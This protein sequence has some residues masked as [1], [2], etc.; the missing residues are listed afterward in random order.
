MKTRLLFLCLLCCSWFAHAQTIM[1][2]GGAIPDN[3]VL[4]SFPVAVRG[5]TPATING[6]FGLQSVCVTITHPWVGDLLL[7]LQAPDGT[8]LDLS[9]NNGGS[10]DNYTGT[11]FNST[12]TNI[13]SAGA[14]PFSGNFRPQGIL[15]TVNNGQNANNTWQLLVRD[16]SPGD[17]GQVVS[18]QL[19]FGNAP[20]PPFVFTSSNLPI[21]VVNT[22]GQPIVD[23]PKIDAYMGIIN[24]GRGRRNLV[25]DP[26]NDFHNKIGIEL[27]GS[28]SQSF[29]QKS[30]SIETRDA[31]NVEHDTTVLGMPAENAWI[32]YAPY[33]D[34]T[35][36]RNVLTFDIANKTGHYA[37][38]TRYCE[39][40]LNGQ[41]KGIYV[42]ME[43]I[44]RGADRVNIKKV[45]PVDTVGN[46]LTGGY[47]FKIDKPT[48]S[49]GNTGWNSTHLSSGGRTIRF[50]YEYPKD[51]N[52]VP[53]Q[54]RYLQAYVDSVETALASPNF[55]NPTTGYAKY[56]DVNSF[57]DYFLLNEV[58]RNV[59][60]L[61]LSTF[62]HKKR[63]SDGG[64]LYAGPAWDYNIAWW[65]AN[66]CAGNLATGWAYNFN[67][68]CAT[69]PNQIPFWWAR[70]LQ[71]PAFAN[72][73][74]CRWT[75]L[76]RTTLHADTLSAFIDTTAAHLN[77][78]KTRHFTVWPILGVYTWPNPTPIPA[79]YPAEIA[80]MKSWIR[81]RLAWLDANMPGTC[82]VPTA[83]LAGGPTPEPQVFP[84]PFNDEL[85]FRTTLPNSA[86]VLLELYDV[87]GRRV[88]RQD[89]CTV[90]TGPHELPIKAAAALAPGIYVLKA[91]IAAATYNVKVVKQ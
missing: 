14:P 36:M 44:K 78:A 35:C 24:N 83:T 32:L 47:I 63:R 27:R 61:R 77:E 52:I 31:R 40:V 34:K 16:T 23:D 26:F 48:G 17:V 56:I 82:A 5:L 18:W 88:A 76:R 64:R 81:Q 25:T 55:A 46:K 73:L 75:T 72:A 4:T 8:V 2:I 33:D 6:T 30:Y 42:M 45:D 1:G 43:K 58:T 69:D 57:V 62:L 49:G 53:K 41:Y 9:V 20:A 90:S 38:R 89:Y 39:L 21:V 70:L 66:Y 7:Q 29:P 11:C 80:A 74:K 3:D 50:L 12:A 65:N 54:A 59:D 10:G 19:T 84:N 60:G 86:P 51:V 28:T 37:S 67:T 79:S 71:D 15:G 87:T 13:I 68:V 22:Q 85:L 91:R